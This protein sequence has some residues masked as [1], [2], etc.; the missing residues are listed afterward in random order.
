MIT[1]RQKRIY[2]TYLKVS[3]RGKPYKLR[4]NF[5]NFDENKSSLLEKLDL[6][7]K[8]YPNID[9]VD[10][11]SA[12][13]ELYPDES[14]DLEFFC[15]QKAKK[16]YT[17]YIK[18]LE[19]ANPDSKESLVRLQNNLK[20]VFG[21]CQEKGLTLDE[22]VT[23]CE[24][25]LPYVVE[26]LKNHKINFYTLHTLGASRLNIDQRVLDFIFDEF[27]RTYQLT[28]NKF[29]NSKLMKEFAKQAKIKLTNKLNKTN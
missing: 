7:F 10:Y 23:Y 2:N 11:F 14:W 25:S 9:W 13:Y 3:R 29:Y 15:K 20:F 21:F 8:S 28:K 18:S 26:H 5:D 19:V 4:Q 16:T 22:Y 27:D 24:D 6:F 1:E 17:T 12:P